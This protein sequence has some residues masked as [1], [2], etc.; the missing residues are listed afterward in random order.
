MQ[1]YISICNLLKRLFFY[2][3]NDLLLL[4]GADA[5]HPLMLVDESMLMVIF[6]KEFHDFLAVH[7]RERLQRATH[8]DFRGLLDIH[9][10]TYTYITHFSTYLK[11]SEKLFL[12]ISSFFYCEEHLNDLNNLFFHY[13]ELFVKYK[14]CMDVNLKELL[15][16]F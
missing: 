5:W 15:G 2:R 6:V 8:C 7:E 1:D 11:V 4:F 13:E 14:C 16:L 12:A 9:R 3:V 10:P